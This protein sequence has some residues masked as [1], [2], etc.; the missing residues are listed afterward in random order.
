MLLSCVQTNDKVSSF[1]IQ[2]Y[3]NAFFQQT[4]KIKCPKYRRKCVYVFFF[5]FVRYTYKFSWH[6]LFLF[7]VSGLH[8]WTK[9][10]HIFFFVKNEQMVGQ[11]IINSS[12][13][14]DFISIKSC[15]YHIDMWWFCIRAEHNLGM[16]FS[17]YLFMFFIAF[18]RSR[19]VPI[20]YWELTLS[21][22]LLFQFF[23]FAN[24]LLN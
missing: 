4:I 18:Y 17:L 9:Q 14:Y 24:A 3:W 2:I 20:F 11:S 22:T 21:I 16:F 5:F 6:F 1:W 10:S 23:F 19:I 12:L 8:L 7:R 15:F 13:D